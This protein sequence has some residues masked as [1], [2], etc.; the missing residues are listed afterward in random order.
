MD[1][2]GRIPD[3]PDADW[4]NVA[5]EQQQAYNRLVDA[6]IEYY[7]KKTWDCQFFRSVEIIRKTPML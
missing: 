1:G 7:K 4:E 2:F 5:E 3:I 6:T